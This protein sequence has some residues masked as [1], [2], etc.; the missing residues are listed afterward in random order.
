MPSLRSI[1]GPCKVVVL[2]AAISRLLLKRFRIDTTAAG[3]DDHA[4][5][6]VAGTSMTLYTGWGQTE[7]SFDAKCSS[8]GIASIA[9]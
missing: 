2:P 5:L 7:L 6:G 8:L 4:S 3:R 9:A 1:R